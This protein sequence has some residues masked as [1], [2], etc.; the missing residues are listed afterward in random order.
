MDM[1]TW[2][3]TIVALILLL[4]IGGITAYFAEKRGRNPSIWFFLGMLFGV[5]GLILLFILPV[6]REETEKNSAEI[7]PEIKKIVAEPEPLPVIEEKQWFY[8]DQK[9][10]QFG[11]VLASQV[12]ALLDK[13]ELTSGSYVWS[14]GM[15]GWKKVGELTE[16]A[17]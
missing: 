8:L 5:F 15:A 12:Q 14:Q 7:P 2:P 6:S 11:P 1:T 3:Q 13:G 16:F 9:K 17:S 4:S 10:Q